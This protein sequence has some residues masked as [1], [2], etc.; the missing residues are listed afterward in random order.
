MTRALVGSAMRG[1]IRFARRHFFVIAAL[2]A[3]CACAEA[4]QAQDLHKVKRGREIM[5]T[6]V[7]LVVFA[8]DEAS[9]DEAARAALVPT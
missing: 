2:A 6:V 1:G 5:G 7:S 8:A 4:Q 9:G 3:F